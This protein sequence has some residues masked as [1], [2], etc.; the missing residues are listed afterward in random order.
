MFD[1]DKLNQFKEGMNT[2]DFFGV[3]VFNWTTCDAWYS[4]KREHVQHWL[5]NLLCFATSCRPGTIIEGGGY[6]KENE[7]DSLKYKD[8]HLYL[9]RDP[10]NSFHK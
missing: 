8:N 5:T 1:L 3:S 4:I 9:V 7:N 10:R 6:Q 2:D